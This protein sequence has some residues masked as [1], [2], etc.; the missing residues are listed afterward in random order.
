[1]SKYLRWQLDIANYEE[2]FW[3]DSK[4][5][6]GYLANDVRRFHVFVANRIQQINELTEPKGW[7]YVSS[8]DNPSDCA[9]RGMKACQL[10]SE[11]S[12]IRG[13][14]FLWKS[15][16]N[17]NDVNA[18]PCTETDKQLISDEMKRSCRLQTRTFNPVFE[19]DR[20]NHISTWFRAKRAIG[21][22]MILLYKF[23]QTNRQVYINTDL[24]KKAESV[25]IK[26]VQAAYFP[27]ELRLLS[28]VNTS[29][30]QSN[31]RDVIL[32]RGS[33]LYRLDPF[34]D[35]QGIIRVGGR[36]SNTVCRFEI[37]HPAIIP[38]RSHV[39]KLLVR[40]FHESVNHMGRTTT[41]N[42]IRQNGFW[43]V[44]GSSSVAHYIS[45]CVL[46]KRLRGRVEV[47]KMADLPADRVYEGPP[48]LYCGTDCFGPFSNKERRST[49]KRYCVIFTC[50]NS[51]AVHIESLNSMDTD[52][53]IN[54]LRRFLARR[55]PVAQIRSD[56]GTNIVGAC[57]ELSAGLRGLSHERI[58]QYLLTN[59]CDWIR[60]KFNVPHSSHMGGVWERQIQT[61][62]RALDPL[63][64]QLGT[65]LDDESFRT[66]LVEVE[67]ILN[68]RPLTTDN[69]SE[70]GAP[71][72]LTSSHL[73]TM[74][75]KPLLAPPGVFQRE[76]LYVR[77]RWRRVQYLANEFWVRWRK[78]FIQSL[79]KRNKWQR[80][81]PNI[82]VD[83]IVL[84]N[85]DHAPRS[86][87]RLARV[88]NEYIHV[89]MELSEKYNC[90]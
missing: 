43:I 83:D 25:I 39:A 20:L 85:D 38:K 86:K 11:S 37:K 10:T 62:R 78:E 40:H 71:E 27:D 87:W 30:T 70:P 7:Y 69:L 80:R 5:V 4:V 31:K 82:A 17:L 47:Q 49:L 89:Q 23:K 74:K 26:M 51:R 21:N 65:Q 79:Q 68:S 75:I 72:P 56:Q 34:L 44:N 19:P 33:S 24:L 6:L 42:S 41:H 22:C 14:E 66:F 77:R 45:E 28:T 60:F 57:N 64:M 61:V 58:Q 59:N 88:L 55:G 8:K 67:S 15:D 3:V 84:L 16:L 50:L 29:Y 90:Y 13:P 46:C 73:L 81:M 9:S 35:D 52:S 53:F 63:L 36:L 76:D 32:K 54:G 48:F 12:W 2:Y 1:M 18:T